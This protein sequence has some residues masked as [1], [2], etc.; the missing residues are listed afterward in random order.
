MIPR[1]GPTLAKQRNY[2]RVIIV[3]WRFVGS[4]T[5]TFRPL[6]LPMVTNVLRTQVTVKCLDVAIESTKKPEPIA[7][8]HISMYGNPETIPFWTMVYEKGGEKKRYRLNTIDSR[9]YDPVWDG[10]FTI[11]IQRI[12]PVRICTSTTVNCSTDFMYLGKSVIMVN[13][14]QS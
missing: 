12:H 1:A 4:S 13:R 9:A 3:V 11:Q 2:A 10:F 6:S 7:T 8:I 14:P 5:G